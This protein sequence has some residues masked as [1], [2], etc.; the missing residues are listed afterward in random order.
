MALLLL[1][2]SQRK[3]PEQKQLRIAFMKQPS[4]QGP[5]TMRPS[6]KTRQQFRSIKLNPAGGREANWPSQRTNIRQTLRLPRLWGPHPLVAI[7]RLMHP[8][9]LRRPVPPWHVP[10]SML[11]GRCRCA[12]T[13]LGIL[14]PVLVSEPRMTGV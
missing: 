3:F 2:S 10:F 4:F 11:L 14:M 8:C 6:S 13:P 12:G 7:L 5:N 9:L 1:L